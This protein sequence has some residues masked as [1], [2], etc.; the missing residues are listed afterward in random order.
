MSHHA[1]Q[2][3]ADAP[4]QF[5]TATPNA[6]AAA[7]CASCSEPIR[8]VYYEVNANVVCSR[9][10]GKLEGLLSSTGRVRR[11]RR[12]FGFGLSAAIAG[13]IFYYGFREVTGIDF[14]LVA[15]LVGFMVGKA[16]FV[17]GDR[18]GGRRYQ[19][20]AVVLTYFAIASTYVPM[21][22]KEGGKNIAAARDSAKV[23][24]Q[25]DSLR[26]GGVVADS[27]TASV[28]ESTPAEN[29]ADA[30]PSAASTKPLGSKK[31]GFGAILLAFVGMVLFTAALPILAGMS[32]IISVVI[33][34]FG[35]MQAWRMNRAVEV[36]VSG[37]YRI[38]GL[39]GLEAAS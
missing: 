5:D 23:A 16:V 18:R 35:L 21:V 24:M 39:A 31:L 26:A 22:F 1:L 38:A 20:M 12:A 6:A 30:A 27:S 19:I 28:S 2:I 32:S 37:P 9:C 10:R 34:F 36:N 33:L 17:G 11:F 25:R 4:L 3:G 14:G 13:A 15:V 7:T 8:S 29:E